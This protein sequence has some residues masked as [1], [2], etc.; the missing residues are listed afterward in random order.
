MKPEKA[1]G[2]ENADPYEK[3]GANMPTL[4]TGNAAGITNRGGPDIRKP[5][6][7]LPTSGQEKNELSAAQD[8]LNRLKNQL[9]KSGGSHE[10]DEE[11]PKEKGFNWMTIAIPLGLVGAA[12][13]AAYILK[14]V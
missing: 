6:F 9:E 3:K 8:E 10:Y 2:P 13:G 5:F 11:K 1:P 4:S 7:D 14:K 12:M